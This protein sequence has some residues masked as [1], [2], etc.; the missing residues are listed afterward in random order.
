MY[1]SKL[2]ILVNQKH[3]ASYRFGKI[4]LVSALC[5]FS[6][7]N[8][9]AQSS[10]LDNEKAADRFHP[11]NDPSPTA[12]AIN[13]VEHS[14]VDMFHGSATVSIPMYSLNGDGM[15]YNVG[16][17]YYSGGV[18]VNEQ[19]GWAGLSWSISGESQISRVVNG[20]PDEY[21]NSAW[22]NNLGQP[23]EKGFYFWAPSQLNRPDWNSTAFL[24]EYNDKTNASDTNQQ[25]G[26]FL[27]DGQPDE[28]Q[29]N[30]AG[31]SGSFFRSETGEWKIKSRE[32]IDIKV[33]EVLH[34]KDFNQP[35]YYYFNHNNWRA[36]GDTGILQYPKINSLFTQFTLTTPDGYKYVF[37]GVD[38]AIE[39][40]RG[41]LKPSENSATTEQAMARS[42]NTWKLSKIISPLGEEIKFTYNRGKALFKR[43]RDYLYGVQYGNSFENPMFDATVTVINPVYLNNIETS[44]GILYF[45]RSQA[46]EKWYKPFGSFSPSLSNMP[47]SLSVPAVDD[48]EFIE[49]VI[50]GGIEDYL[51]TAA[52]QIP[53]NLPNYNQQLD[54]LIYFDKISQQYADGYK[55]IHSA[56]PNSRRTLNGLYHFNFKDTKQDSKYT[57]TYNE[58]TSLPEMDAVCKDYWG[59]YNGDAD[60]LKFIITPSEAPTFHSG[61]SLQGMLTKIVNPMGGTTEFTYEGNSYAK[62]AKVNLS[63]GTV[64]IETV[65]ASYNYGPGCRVKQIKRSDIF[66]APSVIKNYVY[67]NNYPNTDPTGNSGVLNFDFVED[68]IKIDKCDD[69]GYGNLYMYNYSTRNPDEFTKMFKGGMVNYS[70]VT[71]VNADNSYTTYRYSNL[72]SQNYRDEI[73]VGY[74]MYNIYE[75][76]NFRISSTD[77]DR[78]NILNIS[79]FD[80]SNNLVKE[81]VNTYDY[82]PLRKNK[83]IKAT[84]RKILYTRGIYCDFFSALKNM[85]AWAFK[86]YYYN[87]PLIKTEER[88]YNKEGDF[89]STTSEY[90]YDDYGNVIAQSQTTSEGT[91]I[92]TET[93]YNSHTDY[94]GTTTDLT[95]LGIKNLLQQYGIKNYPIE[96]I[97]KKSAINP[98]P[99]ALPQV[100]GAE[101]YTYVLDKPLL[102][103]KYATEFTEPVTVYDITNAPTGFKTSAFAPTSFSKDSRYKLQEDIIQYTAGL[104]NTYPKVLTNIKNTVPSATTWDYKGLL[105]SSRT[106]NATF[107]EVAYAGFEGE[108]SSSNA[109]YKNGWDYSGSSFPV[110]S[111]AKAIAGNGA[112]TVSPSLTAAATNAVIKTN[113]SLT[114]G[115][116]YTLA[117]WATRPTGVEYYASTGNSVQFLSPLR[118]LSNGWSY[119]ETEVTALANQP[120]G[121]VCYGTGGLAFAFLDEVMLYP[122]TAN[123]QSFSYDTR[124]NQVISQNNGA[125]QIINF[126][127]DGL[128][129]MV[130]TYDEQ[131]ILLKSQ[132]YKLQDN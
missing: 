89:A 5:Y 112:L 40:S 83:Y 99:G 21:F 111:P 126:T 110:V 19:A 41:F 4:A 107:T 82:N 43:Q 116:K 101:L 59:F 69:L 31:H 62:K 79:S 124:T 6:G 26:K 96:R 56:T 16:L 129:R 70:T 18:R 94:S 27:F 123:M 67:N 122:V 11:K 68:I 77:M 76:H 49:Q 97:I 114:A 81:V 86:Y 32:N 91:K 119:Y 10:D 75:D 28:F 127:Y 22:K 37:G 74:T 48:I 58:T 44:R 47:L 115:K 121:I 108:Y 98:A 106:Q 105:P 63:T 80:S 54:S 64:G 33:E 87:T 104:N 51:N 132:D 3:K 90:A 34:T 117:F 125:G 17:S 36:L 118:T 120:V 25:I 57:F 12:A 53:A 72:D 78:G 13:N 38:S 24:A 60:I 65:M 46:V 52:Q 15:S 14:G 8:I 20:M 131:G 66:G 103:K 73:H 45:R 7:S 84:D 95:A 128:G 39:F 93:K 55:L 23:F 92:T 29:F 50:H 130:G 102:Q 109:V 61:Q 71:E 1:S 113:L 42:A 30:F 100:L 88:I 85:R 35:N 9:F 2:T